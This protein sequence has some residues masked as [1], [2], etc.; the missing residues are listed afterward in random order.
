[1]RALMNVLLPVND[2][3]QYINT[4][5]FLEIL[6]VI[7]LKPADMPSSDEEQK[8][9]EYCLRRAEPILDRM[10]DKTKEEKIKKQFS[11]DNIIYASD[12]TESNTIFMVT[13]HTESK[14][15]F[16]LLNPKI[17]SLQEGAKDLVL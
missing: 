5:E 10:P 11:K 17:E 4:K 3:G 16:R 12:L 15:R 6:Q 9:K 7:G 13:A 1:M 8:F 14:Y 2:N